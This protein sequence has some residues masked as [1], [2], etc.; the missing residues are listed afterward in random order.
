VFEVLIVLV[1]HDCPVDLI[2]ELTLLVFQKF[3]KP[4]FISEVWSV[5]VPTSVSSSL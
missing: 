2:H 4:F 1:V 3:I 5:V